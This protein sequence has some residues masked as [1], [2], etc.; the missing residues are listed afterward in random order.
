MST[1]LAIVD[2]RGLTFV[3]KAFVESR[4][5]GFKSMP[6]ALSVLLLAQAEGLHPA[7]AAMAYGVIHGRPT[8][9]ADAI[10][11][12]FQK[13]GGS[14]KWI[15]YSDEVCSATFSHPQGSLPE[16]VTW[17]MEMAKAKGLTAKNENYAKYPRQMLSARVISEGVR[18]CFPGATGGMYTPEE[19]EDMPR[20]AP[21]PIEREVVG[22]RI[23]K[24][25]VGRIQ[26]EGEI[27]R[28]TTL[29]ALEDLVPMIQ[30]LPSEDRN[31]L[32]ARFAA[33]KHLLASKPAPE[34]VEDN[35][36]DQ[37]DFSKEAAA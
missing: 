1:E 31:A 25:M 30:A 8:R 20:E 29:Q 13:S 7:A 37:I 23:D 33:R 11:A 3:A 28:A 6:E 2:E 14:I 26:L 19:A 16:P 15:K 34:P 18:K 21:P 36:D 4:M 32:R 27:D 22:E 24:P 35:W 12:R 10:L 5:F 9:K 17:T